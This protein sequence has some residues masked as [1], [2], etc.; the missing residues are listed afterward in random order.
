M[1]QIH[2]GL[3]T[4]PW[5]CTF[6]TKKSFREICSSTERRKKGKAIDLRVKKKSQ[7]EDGGS[8]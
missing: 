2:S 1:G 8:G 5:P 7:R 3:A 4:N 6:S